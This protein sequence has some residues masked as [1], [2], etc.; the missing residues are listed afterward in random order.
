MG[1]GV[2]ESEQRQTSFQPYDSQ[3]RFLAM[4]GWTHLQT[5]SKSAASVVS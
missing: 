1:T 4:S 5:N 3:R 2:L